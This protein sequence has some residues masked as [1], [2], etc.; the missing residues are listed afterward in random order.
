M[1]Y[2]KMNNKSFNRKDK[3][4]GIRY[5]SGMFVPHEALTISKLKN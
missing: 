3:N 4:E 1:I 2:F 5:F